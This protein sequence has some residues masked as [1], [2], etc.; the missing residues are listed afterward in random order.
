MIFLCFVSFI[1]FLPDSSLMA[2]VSL[3]EFAGHSEETAGDGVEPVLVGLLSFAR[4]LFP[5]PRVEKSLIILDALWSTIAENL[6]V[7]ARFEAEAT[8]AG[9]QP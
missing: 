9:L 2:S 1:L 3:S 7:V 5:A 6:A 4:F 8:H